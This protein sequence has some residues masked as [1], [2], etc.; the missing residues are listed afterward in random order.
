MIRDQ[1]T[2]ETLTPTSREQIL[3]LLEGSPKQCIE[4]ITCSKAPLAHDR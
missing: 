3:V 2:V 4:V 1:N